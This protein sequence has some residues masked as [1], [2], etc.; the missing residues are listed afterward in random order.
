MST[1]LLLDHRNDRHYTG[2]TTVDL[3]RAS[4]LISID[5]DARRAVILG[6]PDTVTFSTE[7]TQ[8]DMVREACR[9]ALQVLCSNHGFTLFRSED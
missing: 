6:K 5:L 4:G 1:L 7:Y 3:L 8:D 9:R 2:E